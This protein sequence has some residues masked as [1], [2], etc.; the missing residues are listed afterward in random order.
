MSETKIPYGSESYRK[1]NPDH[2]PMAGLCPEKSE[3]VQRRKGQDCGVEASKGSVRY[4]IVFVVFRRKKLDGFENQPFALK[5]LKDRVTTWL[6]FSNDEDPRL[7][8][9]CW[10][11][12]SDTVKGTHILIQRIP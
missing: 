9:R 6:G 7:E 4:S 2:F 8:W 3:P 12:Q 10:Q 1:R 11:I 5:A